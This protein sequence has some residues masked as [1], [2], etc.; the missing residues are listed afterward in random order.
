[1]KKT[2][3]IIIPLVCVFS[4]IF[5]TP[6]LAEE[7]KDDCPSEYLEYFQEIGEMY[8]ICPELL[9]A[10]AYYESNYH[11]GET[12]AT[13]CQG[14]MQV[15]YRY[16]QSRMEKLGVN[17]LY[18]PYGNILVATDY[19]MEMASEYIDVYVVLV[20]YRYGEYSSQLESCIKYGTHYSYADKVLAYS[21]YLEQV[22]GK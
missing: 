15:S 19:I 2:L 12:S 10:I 18:D 7:E 11:P 9:Q 5:Q 22:H 20:A 21:S 8:G 1:M 6:I 4:L 17:S 3:K 13:N 14:L 16:Q